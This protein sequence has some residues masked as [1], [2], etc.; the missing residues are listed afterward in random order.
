VRKYKVKD[1]EIPKDE[2][3]H[4]AYVGFID[5]VAKEAF[6]TIREIMSEATESP[7]VNIAR[8]HNFINLVNERMPLFIQVNTSEKPEGITIEFFEE[9]YGN[10]LISELK[11][12]L[13]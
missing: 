1:R 9:N 5:G 7:A 12:E 4:F 11:K 13:E 8:V 3:A 6:L 10:S 2:Y